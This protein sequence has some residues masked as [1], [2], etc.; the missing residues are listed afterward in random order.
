MVTGRDVRHMADN[1]G[2]DFRGDDSF[3]ALNYIP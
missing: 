1:A 2:N 3:N